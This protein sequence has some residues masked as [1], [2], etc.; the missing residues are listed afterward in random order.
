M[1]IRRGVSCLK[2]EEINHIVCIRKMKM[3]FVKKE[4][5]QADKTLNYNCIQKNTYDIKYTFT[6]I[7]TIKL[8]NPMMS[9]EVLT[10]LKDTV[11]ICI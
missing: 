7:I 1:N 4:T 9:N 5:V 10:K 3:C 2:R 8:N 6:H 11:R